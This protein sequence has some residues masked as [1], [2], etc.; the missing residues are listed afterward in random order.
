ME[1]DLLFNCGDLLVPEITIVVYHNMGKTKESMQQEEVPL[2][3]K[4][5]VIFMR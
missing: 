4:G 1:W 2:M 5:F 3:K